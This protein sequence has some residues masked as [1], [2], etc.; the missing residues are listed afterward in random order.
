MLTCRLPCF[1]F[2]FAVPRAQG[3]ELEVLIRHFR[4]CFTKISH[5]AR[6]SSFS[7]SLFLFR[8]NNI[9]N[10]FFHYRMQC[11]QR[12][13]RRKKE[14]IIFIDLK[15][16]EVGSFPDGRAPGN[17]AYAWCSDAATVQF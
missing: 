10:I 1:F 13:L 4:C 17:R 7:E 9:L 3:L 8:H 2:F 15:I 14:L 12:F 11:F 16:T 5:P 6:F